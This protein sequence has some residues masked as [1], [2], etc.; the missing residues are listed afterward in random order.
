MLRRWG[1]MIAAAVAPLAVA[2]AAAGVAMPD[3]WRIFEIAA[4]WWLKPL[5]D[6]LAIV[7]VGVLLFS[8]RS[9]RKAIVAPLLRSLRLDLL[10]DL[11]WRRFSPWRAYL[12]AARALEGTRGKVRRRRCKE[13]LAESKGWVAALAAIFECVEWGIAL[14]CAVELDGLLTGVSMLETGSSFSAV[15]AATYALTVALVE[16]LFALSCFALYLNKRTIAEGWDLELR[17]KRL[18][19]AQ[20][21]F[22][23]F[24]L[25]LFLAP[26]WREARALDQ[27]PGAAAFSSGA[28][29]ALDDPVFGARPRTSRRIGLKEGFPAARADDREGKPADARP[30][31]ERFASEALRAMA[32]L[33]AIALVAVA[34]VASLRAFGSRGS[35]RGRAPP[36]P[37]ELEGAERELSLGEGLAE[38]ERLWRSGEGRAALAC[39]Y[40][41]AIGHGTRK[42]AW[43]LG[44][45][46]TEGDCLREAARSGGGFARAFARLAAAW[47]R[48]AW[49]GRA[50]SDEEFASLIGSLSSAEAEARG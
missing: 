9:K 20:R 42:L 10:H 32:A 48:L 49:G 15:L 23:S 11:T 34:I 5:I 36:A 12:L 37:L 41:A 1:G 35:R 28:R 18:G 45:E 13:L 30:F 39:A 27:G 6:R 17:F 44:D 43:R 4:I 7:P 8:P 38:A 26:S 33:A 19:A 22:L 29:A 40:R 25:L 16:P 47:S 50:P 2:A 21:K 46:A 14:A 31:L 3:S 24:M